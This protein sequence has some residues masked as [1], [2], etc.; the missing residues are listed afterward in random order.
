[1]DVTIVN[2]QRRTEADLNWLGGII[3]GEGCV[4]TRVRSKMTSNGHKSKFRPHTPSII[5][6][7]TE[8]A[9]LDEVMRILKELGIGFRVQMERRP[10]NN[11]VT[12]INITGMKTSAR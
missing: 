5:V 6:T 2:Q 7:N 10:N 9:I 1:M 11:H 4:T 12:K 8:A 3:D